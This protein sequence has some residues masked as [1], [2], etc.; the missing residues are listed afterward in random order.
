MTNRNTKIV[1]NAKEEVRKKAIKKYH[2]ENRW[3]LTMFIILFVYV[4][5]FLCKSIVDDSS[6][7]SLI[8][9]LFSFGTTFC[10][11]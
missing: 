9:A 8:L 3:D 2:E 6:F 7:L 5:I 11:E 4:F 1:K 10:F